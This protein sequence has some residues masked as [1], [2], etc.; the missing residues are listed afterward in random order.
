MSGWASDAVVTPIAGGPGKVDICGGR[1]PDH[2][3]FHVAIS[4]G[5]SYHR[6]EE[7]RAASRA[8]PFHVRRAKSRQSMTGI[9]RITLRVKRTNRKDP[10]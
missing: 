1:R 6:Q 3:Q 4:R 7:L 5:E 9:L 2:Q 10:A 8:Q